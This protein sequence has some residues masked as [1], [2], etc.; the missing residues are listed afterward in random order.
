[1][2]R[3]IFF[4]SAAGRMGLLSAGLLVVIASVVAAFGQSSQS[5]R[6]ATPPPKLK[7]L[8]LLVW[9][10]LEKE[11]TPT[12]TTPTE[13]VAGTTQFAFNV[14]NISDQEVV[15]EKMVASCGCTT[16]KMPS[17][18]WHIPP[19]E[20]GKVDVWLT[21]AGKN[22]V[23]AK[24]IQVVSP[25]AP[26]VLTVKVHLPLTA[27]QSNQ[28]MA[29]KDRQAV[30]KGDC[31]SCH[32][33]KAKGKMGKELYLTAC[34]V[35]HEAKPRATMVPDLHAL[36]IQTNVDYWKQWIAYGKTNT[37]MPAFAEAAGGPLTDEQIDSLAKTLTI[38]LPGGARSHP[39][40]RPNS[41][42]PPAAQKQN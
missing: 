3:L 33:D 22:G 23:F 13:I 4:R 39:A 28:S 15:I 6:P 11:I 35:C 32:A 34:G 24:T 21:Y 36:K 12:P 2:K 26:A 7:K 40:G 9:D 37:L 5:I 1:M 30:F 14:T 16:I 18:P 27:R 25:T 41:A 19:H 17:E 38:S 10:A 8:E 42:M 31:A 20:H 29:A